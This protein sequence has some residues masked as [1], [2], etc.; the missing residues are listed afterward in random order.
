MRAALNKMIIHYVHKRS[1]TILKNHSR[2]HSRA[3]CQNLCLNPFPYFAFASS[4][5]SDKAARKHGLV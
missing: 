4:E 5:C 2:L 1:F 3:S